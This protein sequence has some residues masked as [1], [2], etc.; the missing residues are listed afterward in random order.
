[1]K[2]A[3]IEID[4]HYG[5]DDDD[6]HNLAQLIRCQKLIASY[7]VWAYGSGWVQTTGMIADAA[8]LRHRESL[9]CVAAGCIASAGC[10]P[11]VIS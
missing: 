3:A 6:M 5:N 9:S 11:M 10:P 7:F 8:E 2:P 4:D 1:M